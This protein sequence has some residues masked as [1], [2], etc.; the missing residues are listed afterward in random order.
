[1]HTC[2]CRLGKYDYRCA[3]FCIFLRIIDGPGECVSQCATK[4]ITRSGW[5][6]V[7]PQ[8]N[9]RLNCNSLLHNRARS[10]ESPV[11]RQQRTHTHTYCHVPYIFEHG[12]KSEWVR[13]SKRGGRGP[14]PDKFY[15][16]IMRD[17]SDRSAP[18]QT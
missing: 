6:F 9:I 12:A 18:S 4:C 17:T 7:L 2:V 13:E 10:S 3:R 16:Q 14:G 1:M 11:Q 8:H 5:K 15:H